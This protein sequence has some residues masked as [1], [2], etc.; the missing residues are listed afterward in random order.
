[1]R[2]RFIRSFLLIVATAW[3]VAGCDSMPGTEDGSQN[4]PEVHPG[5]GFVSPEII[6]TDRL[7]FVN[8]KATSEVTVSI[9][10]FDEDRDLSRVYVVIQSPVNGADPAGEVVLNVSNNGSRSISVPLEISEGASG[11]YQVV[12]FAADTGERISNR[13]F[14]SVLLT[15]GSEPP[16][17]TQIDIPA[18]LTRP[19]TGQPPITATIVAH[20][21]D[22]DGQDNILG[23]E[24][25]VNG[26]TV[27]LNLC[28]DGSQGTCNSGSGVSGDVVAGDGLYTLTIQLTS[29]NSPGNYL[30]EFT[31]VDRSGLRSAPIT[32]TIVVN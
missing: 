2:Y 21:N 13:I 1:M 22:P 18:T 12:V 20:V 3:V 30:F 4:A 6:D 11:V 26:G 25:V 14:G 29:L 5:T 28:D 24:V 7:D 9:D 19:S 16:V 32:K 17:I 8:G 27:T 23:V 15:A 31:A 10:L